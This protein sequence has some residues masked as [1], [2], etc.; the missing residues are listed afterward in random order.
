MK[1]EVK[2]T[3]AGPTKVLSTGHEPPEFVAVVVGESV[4]ETG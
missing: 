3:A 1:C 4:D 2:L